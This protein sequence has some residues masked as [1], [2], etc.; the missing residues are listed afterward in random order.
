MSEAYAPNMTGPPADRSATMLEAEG[1]VSV[2]A[3]CFLGD[4]RRL[5]AERA[6]VQGMT[7]EQVAQAVVDHSIRFGL[8]AH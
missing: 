4:A 8:D 5:M 7:I 1:M 6:T 2:Q 3:E